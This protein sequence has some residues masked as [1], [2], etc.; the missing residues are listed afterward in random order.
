MIEG[1]SIK[2]KNELV[3]IS[4]AIIVIFFMISKLIF[5]NTFLFIVF[6]SFILIKKR[7]ILKVPSVI[8]V[9]LGYIF[10]ILIQIIVEPSIYYNFETAIKE[11]FRLIIYILIILLAANIKIS[12]SNFLKF[13]EFIFLVLLLVAIFQ[14]FK[15]FGVNEMLVELYG[16]SVHL[17]VSMKYSTLELFRGGSVFLNPNS[18][19]KFI[20]LFFAIYLSIKVTV[21]RNRLYK[22]LLVSCII[23]ALI[24]TGSRT[25]FVI[26]II[27]ILYT[28]FVKILRQEFKSTINNFLFSIFLIFMSVVG[29]FFIITRNLIDLKSLRIFDI[30]LGIGNS[31]NY[32]Y[33]TFSNMISN[34]DIKNYFL[35]TGPY[36]EN[37]RY[38][39]LIDFDLGYLITYYGVFGCILYVFMILDF[40]KYRKNDLKKYLL[41]NSLLLIVFILFS[42]TGGT[43]QNLRFFPV[44]VLIT[45]SSIVNNGGENKSILTSTS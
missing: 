8:F 1:T 7:G 2:E 39:T 38:I 36:E 16:E 3:Y 32:K 21:S 11:V 20:L 25:G 10:L 45:Y 28:Y 27:L 35:G 41:M 33:I 24:L 30:L 29:I 34:F 26:S 17:Q 43:F 31:L 37:L 42:F 23:A 5:L 18:Y 40:I 13:W 4:L 19:A 44:F 22:V 9:L 12:E 15:L 14:F 6:L